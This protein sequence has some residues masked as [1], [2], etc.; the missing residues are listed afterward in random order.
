MLLPTAVDLARAAGSCPQRTV[1]IAPMAVQEI[2]G[3]CN[4]EFM[5]DKGFCAAT[6]GRCQSFTWPSP[7][8]A[9]D[10]VLPDGGWTCLQQVGA[11][12]H[13]VK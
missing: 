10:D 12:L 5:V 4:M 1:T 9:C 6:C 2:F 8:P 3:K 13:T 7:D 11:A